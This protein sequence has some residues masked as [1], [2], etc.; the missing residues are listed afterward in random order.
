MRTVWVIGGNSYEATGVMHLLK[1][2]GINVRFFLSGHRFCPG[3]TLIICLSSTPLL[4]WWRYLR[5]ILW[6]ACRYDIRIIILCPDDVFWTGAVYGENTLFMNGRYSC[7]KSS[8]LLHQ[9]VRNCLLEGALN[10]VHQ[11]AWLYFLD[12][13]SQVLLMSPASEYDSSASKRAYQRRNLML[14]RLGFSSLMKLKVFMAGFIREPR[15]VIYEE[16]HVFLAERARR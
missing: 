10:N 13:A 4:G 11:D 15:S 16:G 12:R 2:C 6:V 14:Q 7:F 3:D 1:D 5:I 9:V 8:L